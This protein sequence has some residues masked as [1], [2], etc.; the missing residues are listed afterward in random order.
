MCK[1]L[2]SQCKRVCQQQSF[3]ILSTTHYHPS[4][5]TIP[6]Y[7]T[8][9]LSG[10]VTCWNCG[11][12]KIQF[13]SAT[14]IPA[15]AVTGLKCSVAKATADEKRTSWKRSMMKDM[16][17]CGFRCAT[18]SSQSYIIYFYLAHL[19]ISHMA[20]GPFLLYQSEQRNGILYEG[21]VK[22]FFLINQSVG[23]Y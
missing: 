22:I 11:W 12:L 1:A 20:D 14:L 18:V 7:L 5:Y 9:F 4:L 2:K 21:P 15:T 17:S 3:L 19:D 16:I 13:K 6:P 10:P 8:Q 23:V